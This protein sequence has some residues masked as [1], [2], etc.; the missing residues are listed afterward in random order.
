[1]G[2]REFL[3]FA[4]PWLV[5]YPDEV[6]VTETPSES[7]GVV[8]ELEVNPEDMGKVIGKRGRIIRSLRLLTRAASQ[9]EDRNATVE[10]V[11]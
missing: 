8:Y 1:M 6:E 11:D 2:S 5:D 3:D 10:L 4:V 7:G 9:G